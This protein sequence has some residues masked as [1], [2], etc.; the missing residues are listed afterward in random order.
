MGNSGKV[1]RQKDWSKKSSTTR[2]GRSKLCVVTHCTGNAQHF[3]CLYTQPPFLWWKRWSMV[4]VHF[5][6][7]YVLGIRCIYDHHK[8]TYSYLRISPQYE[9]VAESTCDD[10][11]TSLWE[12][13]G[14]RWERI[15]RKQSLLENLSTTICKLLVSTSQIA[16]TIEGAVIE[17]ES[18]TKD[19]YASSW[20]S[21]VTQNECKRMSPTSAT[22]WRGW[23]WKLTLAYS[24]TYNLPSQWASV[25]EY[26]NGG[27][28]NCGRWSLPT[29]AFSRLQS[30][31]SLNFWNI[32]HYTWFK[33]PWLLHHH[34]V[35]SGL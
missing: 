7:G 23:E 25:L 15:G 17:V 33:L 21:C 8:H 18:T 20:L 35:V 6:W 24:I 28:R 4:V 5:L 32:L 11:N 1:D 19:N 27:T 29:L 13:E 2:T 10:D 3:R 22:P 14:A 31:S 16:P 34:L 30:N 26:P 9:G 12:L